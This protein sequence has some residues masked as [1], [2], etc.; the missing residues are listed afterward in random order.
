M[1][2]FRAFLAKIPD[3]TV[4]RMCKYLHTYLSLFLVRVYIT[5]Q[6]IYQEK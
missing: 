5:L 6:I 4:H 1:E 3:N 2:D